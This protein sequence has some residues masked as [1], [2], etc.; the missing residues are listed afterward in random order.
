MIFNECQTLSSIID[1]TRK[2]TLSLLSQLEDSN[3]FYNDFK[4]DDK[5]LNSA[6]WIM[7]HLSVTQNFL[8]LR[9]TGG[10]TVKIPYARQ[11]G[12]GAVPPSR[13]ECP[14]LEEVR[15][16]FNLVHEKSVKHIQN[17]EPSQLNQINT[18]GFVFL[19]EDSIR[20]VI[21]HAIRHENM[22]SG[23]L[24]WLCKLNGLKTI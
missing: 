3:G 11:F 5:H 8:L 4:L 21:V 9:S 15:G 7:A 12:M 10:E 18:T 2:L 14:P 1:D 20:S 13:E 22:H 6:F 17:L 24:S 23:H 19:G 16:I